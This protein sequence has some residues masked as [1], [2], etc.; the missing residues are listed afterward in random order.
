MNWIY[1]SSINPR[2]CG[3]ETIKIRRQ[4]LSA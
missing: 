4:Q 2:E 1:S 3:F